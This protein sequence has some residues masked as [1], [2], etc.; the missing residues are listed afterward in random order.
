[1]VT[2]KVPPSPANTF[3]LLVTYHPG[4]ET[5]L[6]LRTLP[7]QVEHIIIIDNASPGS[8][9]APL[10]REM[11]KNPNNFTICLNR[12]N[13]GVAAGLNQG[14]R[15]SLERGAEWLLALDQ[16]SCPLPSLF[17]TL[18]NAWLSCAFRKMAAIVGSQSNNRV[19]VF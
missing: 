10:Q 7:A 14:A 3:A 1:M 15:I 13:V 8:A 17:A 9:M 2:V 19:E 5:V 11:Q 18:Q 12:T 6:A 16:D 4:E